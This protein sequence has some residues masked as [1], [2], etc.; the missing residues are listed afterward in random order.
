MELSA[1]SSSGSMILRAGCAIFSPFQTWP[2]QH[3]PCGLMMQTPEPQ[4]LVSG[5][6]IEISF[7]LNLV[8]TP[9]LEFLECPCCD[10]GYLVPHSK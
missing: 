3:S 2:H 7:A 8:N 6:L 1:A 4:H 10:D 5:A 9:I